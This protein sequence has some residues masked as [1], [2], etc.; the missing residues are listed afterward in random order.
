MR[1]GE[2]RWHACRRRRRRRRTIFA[3][4]LPHG[5]PQRP[6]RSAGLS[7]WRSELSA[8]PRQARGR[9]GTC[10]RPRV[11]CAGSQCAP[12]HLV[13]AQPVRLYAVADHVRA[14]DQL[15]FQAAAALDARLQEGEGCLKRDDTTRVRC[16]FEIQGGGGQRLMEEGGTPRCW[17]ARL[18]P[19]TYSIVARNHTH[20]H[21]HTRLARGRAS[22]STQP[23]VLP[24]P[25]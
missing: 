4:E 1:H 17:W 16:R 10:S 22:W 24:A 12:R 25:N 6:R 3:F 2:E 20:S 15:G 8:Q 5:F 14:A 13:F 21:T 9:R 7:K 23:R 18:R 19:P 11:P